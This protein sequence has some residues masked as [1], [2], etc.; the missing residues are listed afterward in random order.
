MRAVAEPII[1]VPS[2]VHFSTAHCLDLQ[3]GVKHRVPWYDMPMVAGAIEAQCAL[4]YTGALQ[5]ARNFGNL[6]IQNPFAS[7]SAAPR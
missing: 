2:S 1:S 5:D 4:L 3:L 6:W 7:S